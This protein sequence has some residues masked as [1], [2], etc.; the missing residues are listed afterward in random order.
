MRN[1][2]KNSKLTK[3]N[4]VNKLH[5]YM[6]MV[7]HAI[8]NIDIFKAWM[9]RPTE[10]YRFLVLWC[11]VIQMITA[12]P[13]RAPFPFLPMTF[14]I[15]KFPSQFSWTSSIHYGM[16]FYFFSMWICDCVEFDSGFFVSCSIIVFF[17]RER[18]LLLCIFSTDS[19]PFGFVI[20]SIILLIVDDFASIDA[21]LTLNWCEFDSK[22]HCW[23]CRLVLSTA[24]I[25][26]MSVS[27]S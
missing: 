11:T 24:F 17:F 8:L 1:N 3:N 13:R 10:D 7:K 2:T 18:K 12:T 21:D 19:R 4:M 14:F 23:K 27:Q 26:L 9:R 6:I 15:L 16:Y 22:S 25:V 20:G 5:K